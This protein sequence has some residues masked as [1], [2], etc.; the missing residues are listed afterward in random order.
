M[1]ASPINRM[2]SG[3]LAERD[4]A[5]YGDGEAPKAPAERLSAPH[6]H[7]PRWRPFALR[8][9]GELSRRGGLV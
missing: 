9:Q 4:G 1:I 7:A 5:H 2:L 3:S 6:V 8:G